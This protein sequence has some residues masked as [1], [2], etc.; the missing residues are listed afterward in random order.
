MRIGNLA[1]PILSFLISVPSLVTGQRAPRPGPNERY[2]QAIT[3][4]ADSVIRLAVTV[5]PKVEADTSFASMSRLLLAAGTRM[6]TL[7][8]DFDASIPPADLARLHLQLSAPLT[9]IANSYNDAGV[10]FS[11]AGSNPY[12]NLALIRRASADMNSAESAARDYIVARDRAGRMLAASGVQLAPYAATLAPQPRDPC[13][14]SCDSPS[15]IPAVRTPA[16]RTPD[17]VP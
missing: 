11:Q 15:R 7:A 17:S 6:Q 5:S 10:Q 8:G 9:L 16:V 12:T 2:A 13:P 14:A 3:Q 1:V 4:L